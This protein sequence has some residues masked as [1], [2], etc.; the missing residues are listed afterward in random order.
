[1]TE[2]T[3]SEEMLKIAYDALDDKKANDIQMIDISSI[4]ILADYF[5][6]ASG[7]NP[8]QIHAMTDHVEEKMQEAG[9][10]PKAIE[11]YQNANWILMDYG[12]VVIHIF[13]TES[14]SFY[15]LERI[16]SDGKRLQL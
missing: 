2:K 11:G 15:D 1:M 3:A 9:F 8:N 7:T 5:M 4:S 13:D 16:W 12:D 6:I 14:R 10:Y